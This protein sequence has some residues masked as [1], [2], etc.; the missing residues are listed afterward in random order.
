MPTAFI[1]LDLSQYMAGHSQ[2]DLYLSQT[3]LGW[4]VQRLDQP[5]QRHIDSRG[6]IVQAAVGNAQGRIARL[7]AKALTS[8]RL[9]KKRGEQTV[10]GAF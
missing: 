3:C 6:G 8:Q 10:N 7:D 1:S 5:I 2:P 4:R 9:R